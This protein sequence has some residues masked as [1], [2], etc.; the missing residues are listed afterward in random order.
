MQSIGNPK[1]GLPFTV[2]IDR[3][4]KIVAKKLGAMSK[5]DMEAAIKLVL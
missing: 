5:A 4:G 3:Q 2:V 1:S